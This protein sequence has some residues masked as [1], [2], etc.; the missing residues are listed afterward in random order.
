MQAIDTNVLVR[1]LVQDDPAQSAQA[2]AVFRSGEP[3]LIPTTVLLESEWVLR[4]LYKKSFSEIAVAFTRLLDL[5]EIVIP[6]EERVRQALEWSSESHL[7]FADA[8]HLAACQGA[9]RFLTFDQKFSQRSQG[10]GTCPVE[11]P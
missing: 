6:E 9:Q 7:D 10:C 11:H 8:L 1:A 2:S 5:T 4:R 3:I